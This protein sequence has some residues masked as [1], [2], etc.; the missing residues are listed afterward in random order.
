MN[1]KPSSTIRFS[2]RDHLLGRLNESE[3]EHA[4]E[5]AISDS[6][7]YAAL[8]AEEESLI[9]GFAESRLSPEDE[10]DFRRMCAKRPDLRER[11]A[12]E[13]ALQQKF[14]PRR[15]RLFNAVVA[16]VRG[17]VSWPQPRVAGGSGRWCCLALVPA[18]VFVGYRVSEKKRELNDKEW[19]RKYESQRERVAQLK[20]RKSWSEET[21]RGETARGRFA[22]G[23]ETGGSL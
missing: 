12:L 5:L 20:P 2:A 10:R 19:A 13:R 15:A 14:R 22:K 6:E 1:G 4:D 17:D 21:A 18:A 7:Y 3:M 11:V 8:I 9:E 16:A 23:A